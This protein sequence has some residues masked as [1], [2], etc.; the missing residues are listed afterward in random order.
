MTI[1]TPRAI[2]NTLRIA[3]LED[4]DSQLALLAHWLEAAGHRVRGF[5]NGAE[6]VSALEHTDF[7][8]LLLDWNVTGLTGIDVLKLVRKRSS[9]PVLFVS[10]RNEERDI[11]TAIR[12]GADDYLT[13][14]VAKLELLARIEALTRR[15]H[16]K[17]E[18]EMPITVGPFEIDRAS[19]TLHRSG[20]NITL[21]NKDFEVACLLLQNIGRLLSRGYLRERVWSDG[22]R[23]SRTIDTHM[24]RLRKKLGLTP[25]QGWELRAVYGA[26]YRLDTVRQ[27]LAQVNAR[28]LSP[29]TPRTY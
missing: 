1:T 15:V 17:D 26:G 6:L 28:A 8:V 4:D 2:A 18:H 20:K 27:P 24:S 23:S 11:V 3:I 10:A 13:K 12:S 7:E 14:P 22:V 21:T 25:E 16:A 5:A 29:S 19:R 9:V